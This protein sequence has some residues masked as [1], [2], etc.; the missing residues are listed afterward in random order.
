MNL[1]ARI[2]LLATAAVLGA[3]IAW[4]VGVFSPP[5]QVAVAPPRAAAEPPQP[6]ETLERTGEWVATIL[7]RPL[8]SPDRRPPA[9]AAVE[10]GPSMP[11]G[12]PRLTGIMIGPFGR[13]AIFA[14]DGGKPIVV[15]EGGQIGAWTIRA[16]KVGEVQVVGPE[17][18]RSLR[19]SFQAS[20]SSVAQPA[21]VGQHVGLTL[22]L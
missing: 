22:A 6:A 20:P 8:F 19:P 17:G 7:A 14:N 2:G 10:A 11:A 12:L 1:L 15:A 9:Q 21:V 4:E 3:T 5:A 18:A 16:I 13:S